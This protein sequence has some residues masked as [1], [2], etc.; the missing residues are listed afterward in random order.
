M[1]EKMKAAVMRGLD[2]MVV[3]ETEKPCVHPGNV[4]VAL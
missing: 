2:N 1:P 3:I 4:V